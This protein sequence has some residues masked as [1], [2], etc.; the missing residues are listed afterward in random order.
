MPQHEALLTCTSDKSAFILLKKISHFI[1]KLKKI[2]W[3][4]NIISFLLE[5]TVS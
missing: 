5:Y 3:H 4:K 1:L 2:H